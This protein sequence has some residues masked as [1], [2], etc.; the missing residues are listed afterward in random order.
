MS[1]SI[2]EVSEKFNISPHTLRYYEKEGLL[3]AIQRNQNG[4]RAY[5]DLDLERLQLINCMRATGMSIAY[6]KDY[7]D[8]CLLG[9]DTIPER[10][11]IILRQ[12]EIIEQQLKE[13]NALLKV[14]NRKLSYYD[15]LNA[16]PSN[17]YT[18]A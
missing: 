6:I 9:E 16:H 1:Y 7:L 5:S 3:P 2:K 8:L 18:P 10:R 11:Q 12:K 15:K 17:A 13:Y 4:V 14:V